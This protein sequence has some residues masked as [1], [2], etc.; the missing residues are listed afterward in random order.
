MS[1]L[2]QGYW[3]C[4]RV[5]DTHTRD[6]TGEKDKCCFIPAASFSPFVAL[7]VADKN[8]DYITI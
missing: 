1:N 2:G 4:R 3:E 6:T 5:G 7:R 8:K